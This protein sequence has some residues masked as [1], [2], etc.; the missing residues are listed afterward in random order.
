MLIVLPLHYSLL[1]AGHLDVL[2]G[3]SVTVTKIGIAAKGMNVSV[4]VPS[5]STR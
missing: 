2:F 4:E 1:P 5:Q 3:Q